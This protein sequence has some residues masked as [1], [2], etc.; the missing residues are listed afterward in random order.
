MSPLRSRDAV[1]TR[2]GKRLSGPVGSSALLPS[3]G[4]PNGSPMWVA[5]RRGGHRFPKC[6]DATQ[7]LVG[8][9]TELS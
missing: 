7:A 2:S 3:E 1:V 9:N 6:P 5:T 8:P 4:L